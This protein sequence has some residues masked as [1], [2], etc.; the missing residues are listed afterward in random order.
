MRGGVFY[1]FFNKIRYK[2][3]LIFDLI[4]VPGLWWQI[5]EIFYT[6]MKSLGL[7]L[8]KLHGKYL[9]YFGGKWGEKT[10]VEKWAFNNN[11]PFRSLE[12][13]RISLLY[14]FADFFFFKWNNMIYWLAFG[15]GLKYS[16]LDGNILTKK[17]EEM[18]L[19]IYY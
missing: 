3:W 16:C 11:N 4:I 18:H 5:I 9:S 12:R 13:K 15:D 14:N 7:I 6:E 1:V 17:N 2:I 19:R 8:V 10:L